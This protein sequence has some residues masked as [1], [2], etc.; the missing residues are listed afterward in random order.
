VQCVLLGAAIVLGN[1]ACSQSALERAHGEQR[2]SGE[3]PASAWTDGEFI[4]V[5]PSTVQAGFPIQIE[6]FCGDDVNPATVTSEAFGMVTINP[7]PDSGANR[8]L[9]RGTAT[10]PSATKPALYR[11]TVRCPN[12]Q[13]ATTSLHVVSQAPIVSRG[14]QTGGG[15]LAHNDHSGVL[16]GAGSAAVAAGAVLFLLGRRRRA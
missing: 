6:A 3:Q 13:T 1:A 12:Q 2:A 7:V 16:I 8:F 9:H 11:V 14:P 15:W 5:T 10:I 4:R